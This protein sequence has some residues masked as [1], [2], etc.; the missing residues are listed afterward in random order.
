VRKIAEPEQHVDERDGRAAYWM[1]RGGASVLGALPSPFA[2]AVGR[3]GGRAL[4][5]GKERRS[6]V[7]ENFS[8]VVATESARERSSLVRHVF[9]SYGEYWADGARLVHEVRQGR[10]REFTVDGI[11]HI[12][13]A[14]ARGRGLILALPHLG[15][16]EFGG[17]F[18]EQRGLRLL[19][20]GEVLRPRALFDWFVSTRREVGI[21]VLPLEP[22][23]TTHLLRH[24]R[25]GGNVALLADRDVSKDGVD[26]EFF[27][28]HTTVPGGPSLLALRSGAALIPCAIYHRPNG[29]HHA[30]ILPEVEA[31]RSGRLR[32]DVR[33]VA[34]SLADA[35][36]ALISEAPEQ[37]HVL[38]PEW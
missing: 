11:E 29:T 3:V 10:S 2:R 16:W 12:D 15:C 30:V 38:Q 7:L 31:V 36:A 17:R 21:D 32:N 5:L 37:W 13:A 4:A 8:H 28:E 1:Y 22:A 9:A 6:I 19:T 33:R 14:V 24:L 34:Q 25:S 26:V 35:L 23:A 18:L 27:G 20:V